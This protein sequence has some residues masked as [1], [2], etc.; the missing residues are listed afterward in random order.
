[1]ISW[2]DLSVLCF[3]CDSYCMGGNFWGAKFR[4]KS[5]ETFR[6]NFCD[7]HPNEQAALH[8]PRVYTAVRMI[9]HVPLDQPCVFQIKI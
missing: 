5:K 6:I 1:M 8:P 3:A 7:C 2:S 4:E 9:V